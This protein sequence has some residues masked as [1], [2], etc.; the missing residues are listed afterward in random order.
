TGQ[1]MMTLRSNIGPLN[2]LGFSPNG[3]T[4]AVA[5][6]DQVK[7]RSEI[8]LFDASNGRELLSVGRTRTFIH[9]LA[10]GPNGQLLAGALGDSTVRLWDAESGK[11]QLVLRGHTDA[12]AV[13]AFSPD[14]RRVA[15]ASHDRTVKLW[16]IT[17]G[18]EILTLKGQT[19][20]VTALA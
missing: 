15:S 19:A 10:F 5:G 7:N 13:V 14:G 18:Q 12:V 4:V 3:K 16:D 9:G 2:A 6:R 11:E 17:T 20:E 1:E 8:K